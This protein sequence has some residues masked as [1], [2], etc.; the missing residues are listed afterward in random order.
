LYQMGACVAAYALCVL[1]SVC[2]ECACFMRAEREFASAMVVWCT[3][4]VSAHAAQTAHRA[5]FRQTHGVCMCSCFCSSDYFSCTEYCFKAATASGNTAVAVRGANSCA[6]VTQKKVPDRLIDPSSIRSV[7]RITNSIGAVMIGLTRKT[8]SYG[9]RE[10]ECTYVQPMQKPR[11]TDC[12]TKRTISG[13]SMGTI[14]P[15]TSCREGSPT[16]AKPTPRK[17]D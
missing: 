11:W 14:C 13:F 2:T 15:H 1:R 4:A 9:L 10:A 6:V 17:L 8:F 7:Y 3:C 12:D 5:Q 16:Y